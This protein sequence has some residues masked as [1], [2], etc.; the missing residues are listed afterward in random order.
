MGG[1]C[2]FCDLGGIANVLYNGSHWPSPLNLRWLTLDSALPLP[3]P[4]GHR[5]DILPLERGLIHHK[6]S[7]DIPTVLLPSGNVHSIVYASY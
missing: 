3:R 7:I 4:R 2:L 5:S 1:S 6:C